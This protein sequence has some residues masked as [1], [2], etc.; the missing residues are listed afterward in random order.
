M[1]NK[2]E[3][4]AREVTNIKPDNGFVLWCPFCDTW[5]LQD[6][7][8]ARKKLGLHITNSHTDE[9]RFARGT[10]PPDLVDVD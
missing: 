7:M 5:R 1:A 6:S 10:T 3:R 9:V 4:Y 2:L 8:V